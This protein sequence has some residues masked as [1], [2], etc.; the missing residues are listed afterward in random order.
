LLLG[1]AV[2]S[3]RGAMSVKRGGPGWDRIKQ[4]MRQINTFIESYRWINPEALKQ[5]Y[6]I[7]SKRGISSAMSFLNEQVKEQDAIR[8]E[9]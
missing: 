3:L 6:P 9:R 5:V 8:I 7:W 1:L 4:E 2:L